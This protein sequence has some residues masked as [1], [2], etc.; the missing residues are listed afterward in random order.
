M[1][2]RV[3]GKTEPFRILCIDDSKPDATLLKQVLSQ[4]WPG[5]VFRQVRNE[6]EL[7][8]ALEAHVWDCA[9]CDV[10]LPGFDAHEA[11]QILRQNDLYYPVILSSGAVRIKDAVSLMKS[12]ASD[13]VG[14]DDLERLGYSISRAIEESEVHHL[15]DQAEEESL[16]FRNIV[17][18]TDDLLT[19]IDKD[20]CYRYANASY[21]DSKGKYP[22]QLIGKTLAEILG[23]EMFA[24]KIKEKADRCLVGEDIQYYDW[25]DF[26]GNRKC[27]M[28]ITYTPYRADNGEVTGFVVAGRDVTERKQA[29]WKLLQSEERFF[30]A[31]HSH[32]APMQIINVKT[33]ERV[34]V[35]DAC[36]RLYESDKGAMQHKSIYEKNRWV[37]PDK[38][39]EATQAL[40]DRG[41]LQSFPIEA[42]NNAG[43]VMYLEASAAM[44]DDGDL[45][46]IAYINLTEQKRLEK[47]LQLHREHLEELIEARTRQLSMAQKGAEATSK[48]LK[49]S[50][51]QLRQAAS[52]ARL[53]HWKMDE[54]SEK[55]TV[56]SEQYARIHGYTVEEYLKLFPSYKDD[57]KTFHEDDREYVSGIY[58]NNDQ[59]E[60]EFRIIRKDGTIRNV[61]EI[62]REIKDD[63]GRVI[64]SEGTLQDITKLKS[65]ESEL[66]SAKELAEAADRAKSEFLANMSHEIRTPMNAI[67]GLTHLMHQSDLPVEQKGRLSKIESS[68]HHLLTIINDILDIS[69][70]EAGKLTL[71]HSNFHVDTIF[72][73]VQSLVKEQAVEKGL[74][75][76]IQH[77]DLPQWLKG[78][79][80]RV[81]QALLNYVGNAIKFTRTGKITIGGRKLEENDEGVLIRFQVRDTGIGIE[82]GK[83]ARLF[84]AFEQ[85]DVSTT[86]KYGGTGLGLTITQR[87]A[88]LMGGQAGVESEPD[89][90]STFW[91]TARLALGEAYQAL[92]ESRTM[93]DAGSILREIHAGSRILVIE[94]NTLTLRLQWNC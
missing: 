26:P 64:A 90:G 60:L 13:F 43:E 94:D 51:R 2:K 39:A 4:T 22:D 70:I 6:I 11:L 77:H 72:D 82:P 33:G 15:R 57:W 25:F 69:K 74:E 65:V 30:K 59:A 19:L 75:I 80:T 34:E 71:E 54:N 40:I 47:E 36:A 76:E 52:I 89:V 42:Y 49:N 61:R 3:G 86:R 35:N 85:A 55:F 14:K 9:I 67:V 27:F 81:R 20:Y 12:G 50:E 78:D 92:P 8:S 1:N 62:Y 29:E 16:W 68:T 24:S 73:Q 93:S 7:R 32:P 84:D 31:F 41:L 91:F 63:S 5:L 87:L 79:Q 88:K 38:Q 21:L 44:M 83:L 48:A 46:I 28:D 23:E 17:A 56:L 18:N 10:V 66:R 37:H 53:G 58:D 45:A